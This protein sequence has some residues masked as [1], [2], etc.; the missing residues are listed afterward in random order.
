MVCRQSDSEPT[1]SRRIGII[2]RSHLSRLFAFTGNR[3][4]TNVFRSSS[5]QPPTAHLGSWAGSARSAPSLRLRPGPTAPG[6]TS[7][8]THP[9]LCTHSIQSSRVARPGTF[10]LS[11]SSHVQ[12][13]AI[14]VRAP[15]AP[16]SVRDSACGPPPC[17]SHASF[18]AISPRTFCLNMAGSLYF[19]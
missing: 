12:T 5:G 2:R 19:K 18:Y 10:N 11:R 16:Q 17:P 14:R 4:F 6:P 9:P 15:A 7:P 1:R 8:G 3:S 13:P